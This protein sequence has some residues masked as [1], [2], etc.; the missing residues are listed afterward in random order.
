METPNSYYL[1]LELAEKGHLQAYIT[2]RKCL[3]EEEA[4]RFMR[5][6]VSAVD[7]LHQSG[8]VHRDLKLENFLLNSALDIKIVDFGLSSLCQRQNS[9]NTQCGSPAYA[10]PEIFSNR[11]YGASVDMWS[12]GVCLYAMVIGRL[13]FL[14]EHQDNL[15]QLMH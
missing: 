8:I 15:A 4:R 6:I 13:P 1:V 3:E 9:L 12:L 11:R 2:D 7:H 14:S 5:Q 10:A